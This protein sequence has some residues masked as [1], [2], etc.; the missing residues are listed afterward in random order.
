MGLKIRFWGVRG[1]LPAPGPETAVVGGNTSCVEV[2]C[3]DTRI[4]L[5]A[6]TG[7]R[8]LGARIVERGESEIH[9][10]LSH[11]HW[12]HIHGLPFFDPIYRSSTKM[13]VFGAAKQRSIY[14]V[15]YGQMRPPMFPVPFEALTSQ[16]ELHEVRSGDR[17]RVGDALVTAAKL[18]HPGGALGYRIEHAGCS[19][20]YATDTEYS[21]PDRAMVELAHRADLL[22]FDSQYTPQEYR[23]DLGASR[24]GWGHSTYEVG[25]AIARAARVGRYVLFHHDPQRTD[26]QVAELEDLACRLFP[27]SFAAREG[28]TIRLGARA[29]AADASR[30]YSEVSTA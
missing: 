20:V 23:G 5:D 22:I 25:C 24:I 11:Y 27:G 18:Q 8:R 26:A 7:I 14:D 15:L 17:F 1:S 28:Q 30:V 29:A 2:E 10:L 4:I 21:A 16:W 6:G 12:D 9:L 3:G 13:E 19:V